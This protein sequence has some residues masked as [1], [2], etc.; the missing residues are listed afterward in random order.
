MRNQVDTEEAS[1]H[2]QARRIASTVTL[3]SISSQRYNLK[4]DLRR[5]RFATTLCD[6]SR[7]ADDA[8]ISPTGTIQPNESQFDYRRRS[9]RDRSQASCDTV[10]PVPHGR[11]SICGS[12]GRS[13]RRRTFSIGGRRNGSSAATATALRSVDPSEAPCATYIMSIISSWR[14]RR[15]QI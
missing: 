12:P 9:N 3:K 10:M 5:M 14:I 8:P 6:K 7:D 15:C 4:G 11:C 1:E 2:P 13:R